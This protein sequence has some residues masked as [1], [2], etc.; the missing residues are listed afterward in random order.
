M[1]DT[2]IVNNL[3]VAP[4]SS[5]DYWIL[6]NQQYNSVNQSI[7]DVVS[8]MQNDRIGEIKKDMLALQNCMLYTAIAMSLII[9]T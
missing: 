8:T 9:I 3:L 1:V 4:E 7:N 2:T 6:F 5:S